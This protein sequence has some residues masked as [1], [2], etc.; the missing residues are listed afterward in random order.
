LV[1]LG[2]REI[3]L[4]AVVNGDLFGLSRRR[5]AL[6]S[7]HRLLRDPIYLG[8]ALLLAGRA[9]RTGQDRLVRLALLAGLLLWIEARVEDWA[10]R[11]ATGAGSA[12]RVGRPPE[13][14]GSRW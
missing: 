4:A 6:G 10:H 13:A 3:G 5:P 14:G 9:L 8:Y 12:I 7:V 2:L 11:A 1:A